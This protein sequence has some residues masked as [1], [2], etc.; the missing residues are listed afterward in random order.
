VFCFIKPDNK[1]THH[2]YDN[3]KE[4][5]AITN[6]AI[7]Y[8]DF[9]IHIGHILLKEYKAIRYTHHQYYFR[10]IYNTCDNAGRS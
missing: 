5:G 6:S 1:I 7:I 10:S 3:D 2:E 9:E 4:K 8:T